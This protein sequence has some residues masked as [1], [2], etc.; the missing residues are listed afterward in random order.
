L[1]IKVWRTYVDCIINYLSN[2]AGAITCLWHVNHGL[3]NLPQKGADNAR[4][5]LKDWKVKRLFGAVISKTAPNVVELVVIPQGNYLSSCQS[6][7]L[8]LM[9]DI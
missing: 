1:K 4:G 3:I 9:G 6:W 8:L 5:L 7:L 2:P